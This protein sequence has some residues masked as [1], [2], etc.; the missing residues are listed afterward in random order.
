MFLSEDNEDILFFVWIL[1]ASVLVTLYEISQNQLPDF[2][3]ICLTF[4][5]DKE[6]IILGKLFGD[7]HPIRPQGKSVCLKINFL[8]S[9]S[10]DM[11]VLNEM[12]KLR[13]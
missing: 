1:S 6:L 9:Q 11:W 7:L 10:K 12:C 2:K 13:K 3:Q 8:I 4:G 5:H